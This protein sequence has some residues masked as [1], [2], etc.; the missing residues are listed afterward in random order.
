MSI[1]TPVDKAHIAREDDVPAGEEL[2]REYRAAAHER[3]HGH[4]HA[5]RRAAGAQARGI[6]PNSTA[7]CVGL[8]RRLPRPRAIILFI[9]PYWT[10]YEQIKAAASTRTTR[11]S[12]AHPR[13]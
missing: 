6:G 10:I 4:D 1:T 9:E 8:Q 11:T 5:V 7:R 3:D 12:R 13:P 2:L